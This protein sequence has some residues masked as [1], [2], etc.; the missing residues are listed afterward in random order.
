MAI[1]AVKPHG[2]EL[3]EFV[4][5]YESARAG[6]G[7]VDIADFLPPFKNPLYLP[8]LRELVRVDLEYGWR[9]ARPC[10]LEDYQRRFPELFSDRDCL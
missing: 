1:E 8:V 2:E 3:D 6:G 5:A 4:D 7:E 9:A 10:Q